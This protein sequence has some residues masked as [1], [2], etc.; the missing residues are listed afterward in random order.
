MGLD[1]WY[2]TILGQ[3]MFRNYNQNHSFYVL[4][5]HENGFIKPVC[6]LLL[7]KFRFQPKWKLE[8]PWYMLFSIVNNHPIFSYRTISVILAMITIF[9]VGINCDLWYWKIISICQ[10][11]LILRS[12]PSELPSFFVVVVGHQLQPW[13]LLVLKNMTINTWKHR[14]FFQWDSPKKV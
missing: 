14:V 2:W 9:I 8:L 4:C 12:S 13:V 6:F 5:G 3:L 7:F 1:C 11:S 10:Y